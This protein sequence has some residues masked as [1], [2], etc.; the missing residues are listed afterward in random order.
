MLKRVIS[1]AQVTGNL[2]IG[3]YLGSMRNWVAMQYEHDC[4]FFIANLHSLTVSQDPQKLRESTMDLTAMYLACGL[5]PQ[6]SIIFMQSDVK[7][8]TELTWILSCV[9]PLGWL[10]RMTQFKDKSAKG[11]QDV[12]NLGLLSYPVL[13]AADILLYNID[14]VPVGEDQKQHLELVRDIVGIVE[15]KFDKKVF[16]LPEPLID[17]TTKRIMSLGDGNKKMSKSDLSDANRINLVDSEDVIYSKFK[18][19]KTDSKKYITYEPNAR[20]EVTNL[21]NIFLAFSKRTVDDIIKEYANS[22]FQKFKKDLADITI[23]ELQ[24][25]TKKYKEYIDNKDYLY[26]IL[27]EGSNKAGAIAS[28]TIRRVKENFG[29]HY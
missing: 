17:N 5:D 10:K 2:H 20:P 21:I 15:R 22:S 18:K 8:H 6:K 14:L 28:E 4:L 12:N 29:L 25:I 13:M 11:E 9:T 24:P 26:Q 23:A 7:E 27:K 16:S 1:G 19:A 3:N